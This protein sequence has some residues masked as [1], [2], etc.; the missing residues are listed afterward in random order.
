MMHQ[1]YESVYCLEINYNEKMYPEHKEL[2]LSR[3]L[4]S[5]HALPDWHFVNTI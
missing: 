4:L 2:E 5:T 1:Y 3:F